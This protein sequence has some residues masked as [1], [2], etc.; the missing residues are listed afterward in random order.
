VYLA[1]KTASKTRQATTVASHLASSPVIMRTV[2]PAA[3]HVLIASG[4]CS[5][6]HI[7]SLGGRILVTMAQC[8]P[9]PRNA[10]ARE[11]RHAC[12]QTAIETSGMYRSHS[13]LAAP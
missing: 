13:N 1:A 11:T 6:K 2:M 4:T 8:M 10:A 7:F 5:F 12:A 9:I 3:W